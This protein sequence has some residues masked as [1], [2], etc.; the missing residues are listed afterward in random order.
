VSDLVRELELLGAEIDWPGTPAFSPRA[1]APDAPARGPRVRRRLLV[2]I[3]LAVLAITA[4]ALAATGVIH[5]GG[6]TIHRVDR[7]PPVD[8]A[9]KLALGTPIRLS[10]A[11]RLEPYTLPPGL[12]HPSA[13]YQSP[14]GISFLYLR[15]GHPRAVLSIMRDGSG[16]QLL[17]KLV[18]TSTGLRRVR[19]QGAP[20]LYVA[21]V[22]A[23]DF[24]YGGGPRLS[25]PTLLWARNGLTYRLESREALALASV[26]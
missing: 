10:E 7:L 24:L 22:H 16:R 12:A 14:A 4:G 6:A 25:A 11:R 15:A 18:S 23:V 5:F 17:E 2:A 20:G 3:V 8:R 13:A 1:H 19:V 26:R 21:G 9:P